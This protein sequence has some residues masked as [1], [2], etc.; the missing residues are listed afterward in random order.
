[1][2]AHVKIPCFAI[3]YNCSANDLPIEGTAHCAIYSSLRLMLVDERQCK[4]KRPQLRRKL[5]VLYSDIHTIAVKLKDP[6]A[7]VIDQHPPILVINW[8]VRA[9][10]RFEFE[11][12][13]L[14]RSSSWLLEHSFGF[15]GPRFCLHCFNL[16]LR[17]CCR[18]LRF[19]LIDGL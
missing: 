19:S 9:T 14:W 1:M 17:L 10:G 8:R 16:L 13:G 5:L 6:I 7:L 15:N 4:L 12:T 18:S 3:K 11:G 2:S